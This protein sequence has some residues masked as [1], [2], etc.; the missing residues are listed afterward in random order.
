MPPP[1]AELGPSK[2][3]ERPSG[4]HENILG[5]VYSTSTDPYWWRGGW[6]P[7]PTLPPHPPL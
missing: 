3:Q 5:G 2:F 7:P 6:L 4:M 1:P